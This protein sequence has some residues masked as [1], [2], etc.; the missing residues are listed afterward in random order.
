[1]IVDADAGRYANNYDERIAE[2]TCCGELSGNGMDPIN[3]SKG[4]ASC[5]RTDDH[6]RHLRIKST[7]GM[8][9]EFNIGRT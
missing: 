9:M 7:I 8:L 2:C 4:Y 3:R 6:Y 5:H 1:M